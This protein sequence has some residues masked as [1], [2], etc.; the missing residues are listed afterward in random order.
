MISIKKR[1]EFHS[2][3]HLP[4]HTGLCKNLHG[5]MY[6]LDVEIA[7]PIQSE[8]PATG[9]IMDFGLLKKIIQE[10]VIDKCDHR[11]LDEVWENPTAENMIENIAYLIGWALPIGNRLL[12]VTL[13]ETPTSCAIW[14]PDHENQ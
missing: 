8:G 2:A 5:H 13:W 11:L 4:Y 1:F 6:M 7:G 3:H 14:R 12:S 9:M 10:V